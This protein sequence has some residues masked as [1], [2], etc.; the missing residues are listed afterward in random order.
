MKKIDIRAFSLCCLFV[1]LQ[2]VMNEL[3]HTPHCHLVYQ[4]KLIPQLHHVPYPDTLVI[5]SGMAGESF[6]FSVVAK[7]DAVLIKE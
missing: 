3:Q 7:V 2:Q 5:A 6:V 1:I 4:K